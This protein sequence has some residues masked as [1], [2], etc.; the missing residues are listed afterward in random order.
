MA[1][2]YRTVQFSNDGEGLQRRNLYNAQMARANWW[3]VSE[4]IE[5]G[6]F[7]GKKACC[8]FFIFPPLAFLAGR[9][10]GVVTVTFATE[11]TSS[12]GFCSS[13]GTGLREGAAFCMRCGAKCIAIVPP[14]TEEHYQAAS[15]PTRSGHCV[16][17][18]IA[19]QSGTAYCCVSCAAARQDR[20][21]PP[22]PPEDA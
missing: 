18:G 20:A 4:V 11:A 9:A 1:L 22:N 7:R 12:R 6:E 3:I 17:C 2:E 15:A 13:C 5:Q 10:A 19:L 21:A 14:K 8:L 16:F